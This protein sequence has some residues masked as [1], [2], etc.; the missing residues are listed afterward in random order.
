MRCSQC[1]FENR[2]TVRFCEECG[3]KLELRCSACGTTVPI[4]RKFCGGCGQPLTTTDSPA[5]RFAAPDAY[6]PRHLAEKI[7]TSKTALEGERKQVTA[8]FADLK[9]SMELLADRDPEEARKILDP[10]LEHMTRRL[11]QAAAVVGK[12]VPMSLILA[13]ADT[14]EDEVRA[15]FSHL[16]AAEFLYE[17]RLFPDQ[18]YSFTHALTHEVAYGALLH[19]KRRA[20][21]ARIVN[22]IETLH[23]DPPR[24]T[25]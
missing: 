22:A 13:I 4:G 3:A 16:Q 1:G 15:Q 18:E 17:T 2:E 24:R 14:P 25:H 21:H 9:G 20:L 11:L 5:R 8:V 19:D 12:D 10:V 7:L 6:A 23:R